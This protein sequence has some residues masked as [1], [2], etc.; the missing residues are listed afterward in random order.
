MSALDLISPC[1]L[2][3]LDLSL[4]WGKG[5][6]V[7]KYLNR[8]QLQKHRFESRTEHAPSFV[9]NEIGRCLLLHRRIAF[10]SRQLVNWDDD[11]VDTTFCIHYLRNDCRIRRVVEILYAPDPLVFLSL[12]FSLPHFAKS[13]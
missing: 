4:P 6:L 1:V 12:S 10:R 2:S 13:K 11:D 7:Q 3:T 8:G 5:R 9:R